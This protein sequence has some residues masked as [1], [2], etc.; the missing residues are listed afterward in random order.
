MKVRARVGAPPARWQPTVES[1]NSIR[2]LWGRQANAE[3][4]DI[5][6]I[7]AIGPLALLCTFPEYFRDAVWLHFIDNDAALATLVKGSSSVLSGEVITAYTHS[8]CSA[9]GLWSW[10]DRVAGADNPVDGLSRGKMEGPWQLVDIVFPPVL[11]E[12]LR[13]YLHK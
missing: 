10:F 11:L 12:N 3:H 4:R 2:K 8:R 13:T 1:P 5:F 9:I 6:Q 7:E